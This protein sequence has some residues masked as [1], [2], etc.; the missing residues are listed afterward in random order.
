MVGFT[1]WSSERE[2]EDVFLLLETIYERFDVIAKQLGVFKVETIGDCYMA[3]VGLPRPNKHHAVVAARFAME[4]VRLMKEVT[5]NLE[6]Q[7]GPGTADLGLRVG[8]H[9]G[10]VTGGVLRGEKARFQLFGDTVNTASR[11][12]TNGVPGKV[13]VSQAT[14]DLIVASGKHH[15]LV[16][17]KE[18]IE[19]KGKGRMQV[20]FIEPR[21][22]TL[23]HPEKGRDGRASEKH[24]LVLDDA[25]DCES[26]DFSTRNSSSTS[27]REERLIEWN[28]ELLLASLMDRGHMRDVFASRFGKNSKSR[29]AALHSQLRAFVAHLSTLFPERPYH[30]FE[31]ASISAMFANKLMKQVLQKLQPGTDGSNKNDPSI[32]IARF[33]T[34][35]AVLLHD[36]RYQLDGRRTCLFPAI[37]A[38]LRSDAYEALAFTLFHA[39]VGKNT[40][41]AVFSACLHAFPVYNAEFNENSVPLSVCCIEAQTQGGDDDDIL[42][43]GM[44]DVLKLVIRSSEIAHW[45][46]HWNT[47]S[48]WHGMYFAEIQ[49]EFLNGLSSDQDPSQVWHENE[50]HFFK[51]TVQPLAAE[52]KGLGFGEDFITLA[53]ENYNEWQVSGQ[54]ATQK[55]TMDEARNGNAKSYKALQIDILSAS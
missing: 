28:T 14:A 16:P 48:L 32:A 30:N 18:M 11:M 47:Y 1:A 17:R 36:I 3:V 43:N 34:V 13:Q 31:H 49:S 33:A 35:L 12:E 46:Q 54:R 4:C 29:H 44:M 15:W 53:E 39:S 25:S 27:N 9:S 24:E 42:P 7:L 41:T 50:L 21:R 52:F 23:R 2:P 22:K 45:L 38:L 10:T 40:F 51:H 19:A 37:M 8:L 55:L 26:V 5:R 20:Y 6:V